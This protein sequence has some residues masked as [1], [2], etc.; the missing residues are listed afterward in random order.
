M[1]S[2]IR[3]GMTDETWNYIKH[4]GFSAFHWSIPDLKP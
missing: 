2:W 4:T 1:E 3:E